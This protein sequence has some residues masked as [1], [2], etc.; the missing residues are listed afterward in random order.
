MTKE[1]GELK[2]RILEMELEEKQSNGSQA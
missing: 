1:I 2:K